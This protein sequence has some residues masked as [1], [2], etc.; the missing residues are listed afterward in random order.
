MEI[1]IQPLG[2]PLKERSK[3]Q[4]HKLLHMGKL[5]NPP[6]APLILLIISIMS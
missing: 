5:V 1:I 4:C 3:L 6:Q 2:A